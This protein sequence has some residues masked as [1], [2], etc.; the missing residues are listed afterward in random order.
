MARPIQVSFDIE[1][2]LVKMIDA[3][4]KWGY[5]LGEMDVEEMAKSLLDSKG[6]VSSIFPN[7][8]PG[9]KWMR[10]FAKRHNLSA[11]LA[12]NI[13]QA[14]SSVNENT[15]NSFFDNINCHVQTLP[16]ENI[17]NYEK[18]NLKDNR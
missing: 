6:V 7:N 18:T 14:H 2:V 4:T 17:F 3:V 13:K 1:V 5:S 8:R 10:S 15:V 12:S 11:C 9:E 16:P